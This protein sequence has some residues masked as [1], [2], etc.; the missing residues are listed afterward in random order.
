MREQWM[1]ATDT[2]SKR[3]E[4]IFAPH[5]STESSIKIVG[6]RTRKLTGAVEA[7]ETDEAER[8]A[9][10]GGA[11]AMGEALPG[12]NGELVTGATNLP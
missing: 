10:S 3:I 8:R 5:S 12:S 11:M 6:R 1:R 7:D 2:R 4:K 9:A